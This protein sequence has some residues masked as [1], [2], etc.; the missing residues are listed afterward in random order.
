MTLKE[1][2]EVPVVLICLR[3]SSSEEANQSLLFKVVGGGAQQLPQFASNWVMHNLQ[4]LV[5]SLEILQDYI[6][7]NGAQ[8]ISRA[9]L[10]RNF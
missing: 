1:E 7:C 10:A 6:D 3:Q 4:L 5:C 2:R 8:R 9:W